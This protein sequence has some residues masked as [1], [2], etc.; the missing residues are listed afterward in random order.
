MYKKN[1]VHTRFI[2]IRAVAVTA[3][4][5]YRAIES[6]TA[7]ECNNRSNRDISFFFF[8]KVTPF[9]FYT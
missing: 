6:I 3:I 4:S 2:L 7:E 8:R 1:A 5:Q 9:S